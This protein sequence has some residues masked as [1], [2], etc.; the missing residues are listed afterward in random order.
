MNSVHSHEFCS[1]QWIIRQNVQ[2]TARG[3]NGAKSFPDIRLFASCLNLWSRACC[4]PSLTE[5]HTTGRWQGWVWSPST[6]RPKAKLFHIPECCL[7]HETPH[8]SRSVWLLALGNVFKSSSGSSLLMK[9]LWS[10]NADGLNWTCIVL[11]SMFLVGGSSPY[12]T[13]PG[14][15]R[16]PTGLVEYC[17]WPFLLSL[18]NC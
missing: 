3:S 13:F 14:E 4:H 6:V 9:N 2:L 11:S 8:L 5:D 15:R 1:W 18:P 17:A 16:S 12:L 7:L 10:T